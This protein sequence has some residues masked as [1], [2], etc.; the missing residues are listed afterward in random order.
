MTLSLRIFLAWFLLVGLGTVL[1][2][3]SVVTQ[4]PSSI[5]QASEEVLADTAN[6][7][8]ELVVP[9]WHHPDM[10]QSEFAHSVSRYQQ[11]TLNAE[12]WSRLK[13]QPDFVVYVTDLNGVVR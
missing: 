4:L 11:R 8:A 9:A 1:F 6:L 10:K 13:V 2:L 12:I 7:L 3:D 5:R